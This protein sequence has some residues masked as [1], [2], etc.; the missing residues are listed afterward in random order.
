MSLD[1]LGKSLGVEIEPQLLELALTHRS[2]SYENGRGPN[3]ERLE[4]LGDAILGFLVTSHIHDHF[5][6]MDEGNLTKLKNAVVSAPALAQAA[7]SIN[8]GE[9]LLLGKGEI[10]TGG[11]EKMNLLADTFE[12]VLGAAYV[13]KGLEAAKTI[14]DQHI[15]PLLDS[16][17]DLL[18]SADPKTTFLESMQQQ[19]KAVPVYQTTHEG[20]DHDRT[21][22]ANLLIDGQVIASASGRSRKQAETNAAIKALSGSTGE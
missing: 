7:S 12:A 14:V 10:Q 1:A 15:L 3:N 21:F 16:A 4:F 5:S 6:D 19:G 13:S 2:Y 22:F 17:E 9:Y 18:L 8:L 11:R 20:P